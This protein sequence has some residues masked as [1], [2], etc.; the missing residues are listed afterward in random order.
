MKNNIRKKERKKEE[1]E[2]NIRTREFVLTTDWVKRCSG[3]W[4]ALFRVS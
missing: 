1:G 4:N 3:N 2:H